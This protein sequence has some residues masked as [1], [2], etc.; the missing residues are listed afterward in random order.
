M[1]ISL[2]ALQAFPEGVAGRGEDMPI[3]NED[4]LPGETTS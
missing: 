3:A 1:A 4:R 2:I